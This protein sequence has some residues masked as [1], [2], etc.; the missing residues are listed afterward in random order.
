M[1]ATTLLLAAVVVV[2]LVLCASK[3]TSSEHGLDAVLSNQSIK[4]DKPFRA[5]VADPNIPV[6]NRR[7][8]FMT[9]PNNNSENALEAALRGGSAYAA[10]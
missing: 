10:V 1:C 6:S 4:L 3:M 7:M 8:E 5:E 9:S 2:L